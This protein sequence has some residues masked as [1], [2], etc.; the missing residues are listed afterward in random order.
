[1]MGGSAAPGWSQSFTARHVPQQGIFS[2]NAF[3]MIDLT[4]CGVLYLLSLSTVCP[5]IFAS[6]PPSAKGP[7]MLVNKSYDNT[8]L[9]SSGLI[10]LRFDS[11][12]NRRLF[13]GRTRIFNPLD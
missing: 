5:S 11:L 2:E 13:D 9:V 1:M 4:S 10:V 8:F 7:A 3:K 6:F 12:Q